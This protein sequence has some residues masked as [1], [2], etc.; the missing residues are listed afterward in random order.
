VELTAGDAADGAERDDGDE[1]E[2]DGAAAGTHAGA[3][4]PVEVAGQRGS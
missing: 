1:P 3:T 2:D 4:E